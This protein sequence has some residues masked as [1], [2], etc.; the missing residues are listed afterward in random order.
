M[1]LYHL[2]QNTEVADSR[3][4]NIN[5]NKYIIHAQDFHPKAQ[6]IIAAV[7]WYTF[8]GKISYF[9]F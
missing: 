6:T 4:M 8:T 2:E 3:E 9:F 7:A 5:P 1:W